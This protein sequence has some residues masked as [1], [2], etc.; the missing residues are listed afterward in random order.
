MYRG[1]IFNN[2]IKYKLFI[3]RLLLK[4]GFGSLVLL[5]KWMIRIYVGCVIFDSK[6][7]FERFIYF[8]I[9]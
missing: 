1:I 8:W 3:F 6:F 7:E 2:V 5:G 4:N 9:T